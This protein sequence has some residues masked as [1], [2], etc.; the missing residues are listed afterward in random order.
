VVVP[1]L[2]SWLAHD[3]IAWVDCHAI[4][5]SG[6]VAAASIPAKE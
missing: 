4:N 3:G 1:H 2:I 5:W 6:G